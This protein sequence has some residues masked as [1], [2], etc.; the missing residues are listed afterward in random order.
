ML[1]AAF[2]YLKGLN[3]HGCQKLHMNVAAI[4][5]VLSIIAPVG[6]GDLHLV[7]DYYSL[8]EAGPLVRAG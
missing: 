6:E 4:D 1:L 2:R 5:Q 7:S 8:A 3:G